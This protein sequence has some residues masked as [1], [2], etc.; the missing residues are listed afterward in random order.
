M[1]IRL[2]FTNSGVSRGSFINIENLFKFSMITMSIGAFI[3]IILNYYLIQVYGSIG[4]IIATI[5]SFFITI[6]LIDF[7][8]IKTRENVKLQVIGMFTFYKLKLGS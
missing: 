2:F 5:I 7:M 1:A 4:A 3:N 6:F 8:Y